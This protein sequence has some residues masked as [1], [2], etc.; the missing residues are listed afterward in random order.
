MLMML[1]VLDSQCH[2]DLLLRNLE[3]SGGDM[4]PLGSKRGT[5][6]W[7]QGPKEGSLEDVGSEKLKLPING[8]TYGVGVSYQNRPRQ[9]QCPHPT[10]RRQ[11]RVRGRDLQ[12]LAGEGR[13][14]EWTAQPPALPPTRPSLTSEPACWS[15]EEMPSPQLSRRLWAWGVCSPR[16]GQETSPPLVRDM[17][18][19]EAA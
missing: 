8:L 19:A 14:A 11:R 2:I 6:N 9:A 12:R 15:G 13:H 10:K 17:E 1:Q 5:C 16:R 4:R 3:R 7:P 18:Q